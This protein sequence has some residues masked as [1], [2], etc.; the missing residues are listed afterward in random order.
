MYKGNDGWP[1]T[2]PVGS[3]PVGASFFGLLDMAGNVGEWTSDWYGPYPP[4]STQVLVD[5]SGP[6]KASE[7]DSRVVRGG[8]WDISGPSLVRAAD[9]KRHVVSDRFDSVGFR[10]ARG[11]DK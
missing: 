5:P 6:E 1:E 4:A 10:C 7:K 11:P 2:A 8:A 9:R 3:Y